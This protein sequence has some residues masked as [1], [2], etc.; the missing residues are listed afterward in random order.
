MDISFGLKVSLETPILFTLEPQSPIIF[1]LKVYI[2][3]ENQ[4][5]VTIVK[6][7]TPLDPIAGSL[8]IFHICDTS[9]GETLAADIIKISRKLPAS[10]NDFVQID[11]GQII[12]CQHDLTGLNFQKDH[13]YSFRAQGTWHAVLECP[14]A[15]IT[16]SQIQTLTGHK[17]GEFQSE[18]AFFTVK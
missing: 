5:P 17:R 11:G 14:L 7:N 3:N 1:P 8:G 18:F 16:A 2:Q 9:S 12:Q 4:Y 6:W 13:E 10:Q 15:D